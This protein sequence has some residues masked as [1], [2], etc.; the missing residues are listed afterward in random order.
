VS[1][2]A[3]HCTARPR[4]D[5]DFLY[6]VHDRTK[7]AAGISE[8]PLFRPVAN[9]GRLGT[10]RLTDKS[11]CDLAGDFGAHSRQPHKSMDVLQAYVRDADLFCN[12]AGHGL[13]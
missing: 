6:P 7:R 2:T 3:A 1:R 8:G 13:L 5:R 10:E 4:A 11:V 12:H 9:G